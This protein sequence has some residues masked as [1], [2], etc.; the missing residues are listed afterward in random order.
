MVKLIRE[1]LKKRQPTEE[2]QEEIDKRINAEEPLWDDEDENDDPDKKSSEIDEKEEEEKEEGAEEEDTDKEDEEKED[3]AEEEENEE[4]D[5]NNADIDGKREILKQKETALETLEDEAEKSALEV[6]IDQ[7]RAVLESAEKEAEK[8]DTDKVIKAYA[9]AEDVT[10]EEARE[11][12]QKDKNIIEK[13][14]KDPLKMAKAYRLSQSEYMRKAEEAEKLGKQLQAMQLQAEM[15]R[16]FQP[17]K[18]LS[19]SLG[20]EVSRE[21]VIASYRRQYPGITK[22]LED[23]AVYDHVKKDTLDKLRENST[24]HAQMVKEKA[25]DRRNIL[26]KSIPDDVKE[27]RNEIEQALESVPDNRVVSKDFSLNDIIYWT[28]GKHFSDIDKKI[29]EAEN[30]GFKRGVEQRKIAGRKTSGGGSPR[31]KKTNDKAKYHGLDEKQRQKALDYFANNPITETRKYAL[32]AEM[33][34][35]DKELEK[36]NK[37]GN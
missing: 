1:E 34:E 22:D 10:E 7:M 32:Y 37:G 25:K 4:S 29:K 14:G 18:V 33:V 21:E 28:R 13:Y 35:F 20:K 23:D 27:Y 9:E 11:I 26:I 5:F 15:G 17:E 16:D 31:T 19:A 8:A 24:R 36:K 2:E 6:E 12:Y 30:R 3:E